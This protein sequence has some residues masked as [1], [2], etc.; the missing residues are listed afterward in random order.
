MFRF[1]W[2]ADILSCHT[3]FWQVLRA[4]DSQKERLAIQLVDIPEGILDAG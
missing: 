1:G 2:K 3:S 4:N